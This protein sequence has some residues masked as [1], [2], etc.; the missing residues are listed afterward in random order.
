M[1]FFSPIGRRTGARLAAAAVAVLGCVLH[2]PAHAD[3]LVVSAA[4]S[5]TDAFKNIA[6]A[7]EQQH[8]GTKVILNFGASDILMRQIANGAPADVFAS[9]DQT[10]M[11]KA[12][13]AGVIDTASRVDFAA[14]SLVMIVPADGKL[15]LKTPHELATRSDVARV[16]LADPASVPAG[17]Y[18]QKAL[19]ADS[20][21]LWEAIKAKAVL[22]TNVRQCLDYV[23]RGEVEAGFVFGTDAAIAGRRVKVAAT[24]PTPQPIAYPIAIVK[25]SQH[26]GEAKA[27]VDYVRSSA[28]QTTLVKYGFKPAAQ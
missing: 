13:G 2:Q 28:G 6:A 4:T 10:A 18:T 25:T 23:A 27:F 21:Q 20:K 15:A 11:D 7:F 16:A 8:P 26:A 5:L 9:A 24:L 14:N 19:E 12:V 22:A 3:E 17:R 1:I